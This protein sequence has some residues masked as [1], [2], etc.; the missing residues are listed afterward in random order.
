MNLVHITLVRLLSLVLYNFST[1]WTQMSQ[2]F[3]V[4]L[5]IRLT[6]NVE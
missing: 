1:N 6:F 2:R 5:N 3:M 4:K